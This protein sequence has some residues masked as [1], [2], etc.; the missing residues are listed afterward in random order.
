[1]RSNDKQLNLGLLGETRQMIDLPYQEV[2][3]CSTPLQAVKHCMSKIVY[4]EDEW[5]EYLSTTQ[6]TLNQILNSDIAKRRKRNFPLEWINLI[7]LKAGNRCVSQYFDLESKGQLLSQQR[8]ETELTTEE[9]AELF[10][11]MRLQA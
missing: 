6:G 1:M 10:D 8:Q 11:Q 2:S 5:A 4:S 3:Q 7:Q 9:K